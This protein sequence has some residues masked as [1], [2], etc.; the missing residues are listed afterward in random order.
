MSSSATAAHSSSAPHTTPTAKAAVT[1]PPTAANPSK[2]TLMPAHTA[3]Q[4]CWYC[5][6]ADAATSPTRDSDSSIVPLLTPEESKKKKKNK[7]K[8]K[9]KKKKSFFVDQDHM[10]IAS[11]K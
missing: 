4:C 3:G 5:R 10:I 7:K 2:H 1:A 11:W 8:K 9:K 6:T